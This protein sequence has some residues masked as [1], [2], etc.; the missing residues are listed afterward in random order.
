MHGTSFNQNL[1]A[2]LNDYISRAEALK[3]HTSSG[4]KSQTQLDIES[5]LSMLRQALDKD[6]EANLKEAFELYTK[7]VQIYIKIVFESLVM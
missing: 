5:S 2:K 7:A 6:Q 3:K 1:Q 4:T